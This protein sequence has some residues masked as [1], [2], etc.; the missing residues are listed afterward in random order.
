MSNEII[1][2]REDF[3]KENIEVLMSDYKADSL[4]IA[5]IDDNQKIPVAVVNEINDL[6]ITNILSYMTDCKYEYP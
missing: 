4:F 6:F 5:M 3:T 1:L 2:K